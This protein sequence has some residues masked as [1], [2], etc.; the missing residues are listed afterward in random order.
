MDN[1]YS[2]LF[3]MTPFFLLAL[4]PSSFVC[5]SVSCWPETTSDVGIHLLHYLGEDFWLLLHCARLCTVPGYATCRLWAFSC[6][7]LLS[8]HGNNGLEM[9]ATASDFMWRLEIWTQTLT[10][11]RQALH[12]L[13]DLPTPNMGYSK[14]KQKR[15]CSLVQPQGPR[16]MDTLTFRGHIFFPSPSKWK[17]KSCIRKV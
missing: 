13:S 3:L 14:K 5:L 7:C 2:I 9:N 4:L 8:Y 11:A 10:L 15:P 6:F 1:G 17:M 16:Y 12:P